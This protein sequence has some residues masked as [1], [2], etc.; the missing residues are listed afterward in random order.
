MI[1]RYSRFLLALSCTS[2]VVMLSSCS[3]A[4]QAHQ[5][6]LLT[7]TE[8]NDLKV[9]GSI[10]KSAT[11]DDSPFYNGQVSYSPIKHVGVAAKYFS[12]KELLE[13]S[14]DIFSTFTKEIDGNYM[15]VAVGGYFGPDLKMKTADFSNKLLMPMGLTGDLY[16]GYGKGNFHSIYGKT[17]EQNLKFN[18]LSIQ[19]GLHFNWKI[20]KISYTYRLMSLVYTKIDLVGDITDENF[21]AVDKLTSDNPNIFR[22][23]SLRMQMGPRHAQFFVDM[24]FNNL[25]ANMRDFYFYEKIG[26]IGLIIDINEFYKKVEMT[27]K[28]D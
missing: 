4:F 19:A 24:N 3:T 21:E 23:S 6:M 1:S 8:K 26:G 5:D 12:Y 15:E 22:S 27:R 7:V 28:I 10:N 11:V 20:V 16:L 13:G 14:N 9:T 18:R 2:L 17:A 25:P